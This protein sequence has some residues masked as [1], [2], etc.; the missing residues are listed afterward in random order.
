MSISDNLQHVRARISD[1][2]ARVSRDPTEVTLVA[3]SKQHP[4]ADIL[5]AIDAGQLHFGENRLEEMREKHSQIPDAVTWHMV[6]HI[7]SRKAR[8]IP[9]YFNFVHSVDSLHLAQKL[10]DAIP[11]YQKPMLDVLLQIN[12]SGESTKSGFFAVDWANNAQVRA[13]L[14]MNI[15]QILALPY[16]HV[17]GLMT[18]A[19]IADNPEKIR[20]V[21]IGLRNLRDALVNDLDVP[22]PQLSMGMTDD[23]EIAIEEGATLVRI[24]R[25]IFEG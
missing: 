23:F 25:A 17:V 20:P 22:L 24:G 21:F 6:G 8:D 19:F 11:R 1:A 14:W 18:M 9:A 13:D 5:S 7:Q 2:C 12:I 10:S 16:L 15:R 4:V 3:V